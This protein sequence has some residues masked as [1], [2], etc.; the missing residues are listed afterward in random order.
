MRSFTRHACLLLLLF[1]ADCA[2]WHSE[3]ESR[4]A[5]T[6]ETPAVV[7]EVAAANGTPPPTFTASQLDGSKFPDGVLA[8]TWD[9]GPDRHSLELARYLRSERV[10][11]TF[12]V[13]Q[14]WSR[15]LSSYPGFGANVQNSGYAKI[16]ILRELVGLGHR[17]GNHTEHHV[18]LDRVDAEQARH[19]LLVEQRNLAPYERSEL[20]LFRVPGGSWNGGIAA[21]ENIAPELRRLVGPVRWDV[22]RKDWESSIRCDSAQPVVECEHWG[23]GERLKP[24]VTAARYLQSISKARHGIVLLHDRVADVGSRYA[25]DVA[26]ALVPAL[27]DRGFVFASPVLA[28]SPWKERLT[29]RAQAMLASKGIDRWAFYDENRDGKADLC[30]RNDFGWRCLPSI[31]VTPSAA[32]RM[33]KSMFDGAVQPQ[34]SPASADAR[35]L[36]CS[37]R[38]GAA[39]RPADVDGDGEDECCT[40]MEAGIACERMRG[41]GA[42][43]RASAVWSADPVFRAAFASGSRV[44]FGDLNGD[45]RAD[46]CTLNAG[47]VVC[48]F[49]TGSSFTRPTIWARPPEGARANDF[50]LADVNGDSRADLCTVEKGHV[51]CGLAP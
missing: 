21:E 20:G 24:A 49:S 16:P 15:E 40:L 35:A 12:F 39:A 48:A 25:L 6:R 36:E 2:V 31:E 37:G 28:F 11:A 30:V 23:D 9:D 50:A 38:L 41:A 34:S 43:A 26:R 45:Q 18:Y 29:A 8:L 17:V 10:S 46:V 32:D 19:E 27:I 42:G 14:Q 4:A 51:S 33:P 44:L 47:A 5:I 1:I 13:V 22:D 3:P 7:R